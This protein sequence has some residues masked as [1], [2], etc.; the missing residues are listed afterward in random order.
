[1]QEIATVQEGDILNAGRLFCIFGIAIA[2]N[3]D[4]VLI[5]QYTL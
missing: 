1:M 4:E 2:I 5:D 3:D